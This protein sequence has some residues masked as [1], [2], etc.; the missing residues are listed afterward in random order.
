MGVWGR[1][2]GRVVL[3]LAVFLT[4]FLGAKLG[5]LGTREVAA[6]HNF[7]DVPDSAFYHA[8]VQFLVDNG[9]TAGC[10]PGLFCGEQAVTRGQ[11]AVFLKK[12]SDLVDQ[13]VAG[14]VAGLSACPPDS[15]KVG[16]TCIDK[17][18]A[19]VW[20]VPAASVALIEKIK[21]GTVT[22]AELQAGAVQRGAVGDD[23]GAECPG[24]GNGCLNL[25]AVSIAA[26]TPSRFLTWFQATAAARNAGKRLPTNAEW[27]A[28]ALGTPDLGV[29]EGPQD[30]NTQFD[31]LPLISLTGARANCVSDAGAFDTVG[32]LQEWVA[33]WSPLATT[34]V[35]STLF[36]TGDINCVGGADTTAGP[37]ALL[38][39]SVTF[40]FASGLGAG[41]FAV[42]GLITPSFVDASHGFRA[43]R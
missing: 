16:R 27:Q 25:Y 36:A 14:A 42:N 18:E 4:G 11:T 13:R 17:Y 2:F 43:A 7:S 20:E 15:V 23:Y 31:D 39:G 33:D 21:A 9:I 26:V 5:M 38:R 12:L 3:M 22:L 40:L 35:P 32:N 6:S 29:V 19:S 28:A 8:F 34:C 24:T 37:A 30:C 41:V 1:L 10:G